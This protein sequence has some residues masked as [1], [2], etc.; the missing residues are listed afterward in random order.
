[1][2]EV[3]ETEI[4]LFFSFLVSSVAGF[5]GA[6]ISVPLCAVVL[7]LA[8]AKAVVNI[9]SI[10]FNSTIIVQHRKVLK[11]KEL[12]PIFALVFI[13][14][15]L[16]MFFNSLVNVEEV[17]IRILGGIILIITMIKLLCSKEIN[18]NKTASVIVLILSGI[19]NYLFLCGGIVYM[20]MRY[21]EKEIFRASNS[22]LFLLQ[23]LYIMVIQY[24]KGLYTKENLI[25]GLIGVIP[26]IIATI[27]GK[28]IVNVISQ[29]KF[30]KMTCVLLIIMAIMLI[31]Q[32][33]HIKMCLCTL[34]I[35]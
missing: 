22:F 25:I 30:E 32:T 6:A 21:K 24:Y 16:G 10:A 28:Q 27:I 33:S 17:L 20:S 26:V 12:L 8:N 18:L 34:K 7:G 13:G 9:I 31:T 19:V 35:Q 15:I 29:E 23:S 5:A 14:M 11:V 3:I 1:M 2:L 4:I